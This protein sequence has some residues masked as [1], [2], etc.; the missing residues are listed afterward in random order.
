M[1]QPDEATTFSYVIPGRTITGGTDHVLAEID[2][3]VE[4]LLAVRQIAAATKQKSL[5]RDLRQNGSL[6]TVR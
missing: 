5:R 2:E 6:P 4:S 3:M 1:E